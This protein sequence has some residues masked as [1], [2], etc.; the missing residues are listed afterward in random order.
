VTF[1]IKDSALTAYKRTTNDRSELLADI[2]ELYYLKGMNQSEIASQIGVDRSMVSRMLAE[3]RARN[4]VEISVKKPL[5]S[6]NTLENE[7]IQKFGLLD[8]FVLNNREIEYK[9]LLNNLGKAGAKV[10]LSY[11]SQGQVLGLSWGSAVSAVVEA[12]KV[13]E[14]LHIRVVQLVGAMGAQNTV[15]DGPGLVQRLAQ[16]FGC[17]GY[18]INA[19]FIVD[20]AEIVGALQENRNIREAVD[21]AKKC[22]I[23]VLGI[24]STEPEYS[25]FYQA[26]YVPFE[27]LE[28]LRKFGM[29]GDVCGHHFGEHGETPELEFHKRIITIDA[30]S[31]KSI[32]VRI[33]VAGGIGKIKAVLGALR[34]G[35][36]NVLVTDSQLV[37]RL[38]SV[39]G[40]I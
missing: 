26:G 7:L 36:I 32:P 40:L 34:A 10:L 39:E 2:A 4:I 24:G 31:L 33:G 30:K 17:E 8:A 6:D 37:S 27:V 25:S 16:K 28:Q 15:Y 35:Y 21:L 38:V 3:A 22:D 12:V 1:L 9:E 23:A 20:T 14:P 13:N 5:S 11:I 19:P 29:V 18:F